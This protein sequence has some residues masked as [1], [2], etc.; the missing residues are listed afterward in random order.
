MELQKLIE[1]LQ[2]EGTTPEEILKAIK[3]RRYML[4]KVREY[5]QRTYKKITISIRKD[6]IAKLKEYLPE[7]D[8]RYLIYSLAIRKLLHKIPKEIW[9]PLWEKTKALK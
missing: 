8:E 2:E 6:E 3:Q 5:Q 1:K 9:E 7:L 4:Q